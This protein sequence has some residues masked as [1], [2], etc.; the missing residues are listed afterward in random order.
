MINDKTI[1][2][3][4]RF[5]YRNKYNGKWLKI[6]TEQ[7]IAYPSR[8]GEYELITDASLYMARNIIEEDFSHLSIDNKTDYEL[9]EIIVSF[10]HTKN[11]NI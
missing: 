5:V 1:H 6:V 4:K 8:E 7:C 2:T 10:E 3:E 9:L 11:E